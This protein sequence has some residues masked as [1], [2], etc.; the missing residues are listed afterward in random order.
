MNL[1]SIRNIVSEAYAIGI[2]DTQIPKHSTQFTFVDTPKQL[3]IRIPAYENAFSAPLFTLIFQVITA[4]L[5]HM[6]ITAQGLRES[7]TAAFEGKSLPGDELDIR[8]IVQ[9]TGESA[10]AITETRILVRE[11]T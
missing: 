4:A 6:K 8:G 11:K 3:L 1:E 7:L 9:T 5:P 2:A 10:H